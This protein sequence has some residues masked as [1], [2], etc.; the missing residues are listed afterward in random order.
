M[1]RSRIVAAGMLLASQA[2]LAAVAFDVD[3]WGRDLLATRPAVRAAEQALAAERHAAEALRA[4]SAEWTASGGLAQRRLADD[5]RRAGEWEFAVQRPWR[6]ASRRQAASD[7][8][9]ARLQWAL[10]LRGQAWLGEARTLL[11]RLAAWRREEVASRLWTE[12]VAVLQRQQDAMSRRL[13]QGDVARVEAMQI[14]ATL[15]QAKSQAQW[16]EARR[17]AALAALR[18]QFGAVPP[19]LPAATG[20]S[21]SAALDVAACE[22][23]HPELRVAEA[24]HAVA[25]A[26]GRIDT[27]E[28]SPEFSWGWKVGGV[29]RTGERMVGLTLSV[30]LPGAQRASQA[31]ASEA[32]ERA[33]AAAVEGRQLS[34]RADLERQRVESAELD[35]VWRRADDAARQ[36]EDVAASLAR[37]WSLGEGQLQDVLAARRIAVEQ[38][39]AAALIDADRQAAGLRLQ[40]ECGRIWPR[41][42]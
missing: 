41:D 42:R 40:L 26:Q 19:D 34:L 31:Q 9:D 11:D 39:L 29:P 18:T 14:E 21:E 6:N 20:S 10:A 35:Q 27:A 37:G 16:A 33:S 7:M 12:Q 22:A 1:R 17:Q 2:S 30:P 36:L 24:E 25:R 28:R 38:R 15:G 32:R 5:G 3:A 13:R 23:Q 8:A 4:G